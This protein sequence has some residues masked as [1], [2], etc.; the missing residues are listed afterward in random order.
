AKHIPPRYWDGLVSGV[1]KSPCASKKARRRLGI[2]SS[3]GAKLPEISEH[4]PPSNRGRCSA[5][6]VC[7]TLSWMAWQL[8]K[9]ARAIGKERSKGAS[10]GGLLPASD[11]NRSSRTAGASS[12]LAS[13]FGVTIPACITRQGFIDCA[14]CEH[15]EA[16]VA[17]ASLELLARA[18]HSCKHFPR[19]PSHLG[20]GSGSPRTHARTPSLCP[21]DP[22]LSAVDRAGAAGAYDHPQRGTQGVGATADRRSARRESAG[23]DS[24]ERFPSSDLSRLRPIDG[25][26]SQPRAAR[27]R[28][29]ICGANAR[30]Q[31]VF[32]L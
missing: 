6:R 26:R 25:I 15:Q 19:A 31:C 17:R 8:R 13:P 2:R 27:S 4:S 30:G 7:S 11:A 23:G 29:S 21:L 12:V 3:A 32:H 9:A 10:S 14:L 24:G 1:L 28:A 16:F 5:F 22:P 20:R 18:A